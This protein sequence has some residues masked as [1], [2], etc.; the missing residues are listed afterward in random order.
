MMKK[1]TIFLTDYIAN[2]YPIEKLKELIFISIDIAENFLLSLESGFNYN[3][4]NVLSYEKKYG[5]CQKK[6]ILK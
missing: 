2:Q 1:R 5:S 6:T 4:S 3:F